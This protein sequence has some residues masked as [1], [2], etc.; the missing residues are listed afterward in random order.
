MSTSDP[1]PPERRDPPFAGVDWEATPDWELDT[2]VG[3]EPDELHALHDTLVAASDAHVENA[4]TAG[5]LDTVASRRHQR[6]GE[7]LSLRWILL[8][9]VDEHARHNGHADLLREA[10]DGST[11]V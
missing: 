6:T 4:L 9:L 7:D 1:S 2:A 10:V 11:G 5:G 8:H 3:H